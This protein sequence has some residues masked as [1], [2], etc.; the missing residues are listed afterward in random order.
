MHW[1]SVF[2]KI[3]VDSAKAMAPN[4]IFLNMLRKWQKHLNTSGKIR[5]ILTDLNL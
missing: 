4:I 5:A 3:F 1:T 2:P